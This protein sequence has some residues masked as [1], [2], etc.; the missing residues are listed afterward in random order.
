MVGLVAAVPQPSLSCLWERGTVSQG[1]RGGQSVL[2]FLFQHAPRLPAAPGCH[3]GNA[4]WR[5]CHGEESIGGKFPA[6]R[7]GIMGATTK[8]KQMSE[9]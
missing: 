3:H 9:M 5:R 4:T 6:L 1:L 2:F 8:E 7:T